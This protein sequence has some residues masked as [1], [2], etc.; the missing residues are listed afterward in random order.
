MSSN[1]N[2]QINILNQNDFENTSGIQC[3]LDIKEEKNQKSNKNWLTK[4]RSGKKINISNKKLD[5][6]LDINLEGLGTIEFAKLHRDANRPLKK[7]KE[8]DEN[9]E[10]CPCC[11]LPKMKKGYI[12]TFKFNDN[13]D[14]FIECG[15]GIPLYFSFFRF[16]LFILLLTSLLISLPTS[17]VTNHYTSRIIENCYKISANIEINEYNFPECINYIGINGKPKYSFNSSDWA[18]RFNG[19]NLKQ[20]KLLH[21]HLTETNTKQAEKALIDYNFLFFLSLLTLYIINLIYIIF[22]YN[23]NKRNDMLVTTPSDYTICS[24]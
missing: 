16:C 13:T 15:K 18:L 22:I 1:E 20:Y 7:I 2:L 12:E 19:I 3:N 24:K 23:I 8:L 10:F 5:F 14:E 21:F 11:S 9:V 17:I 4:L 6:K